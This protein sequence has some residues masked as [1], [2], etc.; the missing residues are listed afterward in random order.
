M[1]HVKTT[2]A[3]RQ[4][5]AAT[6]PW[7]RKLSRPA[8]CEGWH[9]ASRGRRPCKNLAYW[10][11]RHLRRDE[12]GQGFG[13]RRYCWNHLLSRGLYGSMAEDARTDRW[14]EAHPPP[15]KSREVSV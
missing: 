13:T 7:V 3:E 14:M 8:A 1:P 10:S 15:W 5:Y 4:A 9:G 11:F 12:F 2:I 6:I